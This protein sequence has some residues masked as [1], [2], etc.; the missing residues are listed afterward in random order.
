MPTVEVNSLRSREE[1]MSQYY[2]DMSKLDMQPEKISI[3]ASQISN[4]AARLEKLCEQY[5]F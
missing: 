3:A 1:D 5:W 2:V 4:T